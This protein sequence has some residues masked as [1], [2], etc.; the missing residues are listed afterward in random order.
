MH[1]NVQEKEPIFQYAESIAFTYFYFFMYS[2]YFFFFCIA[3][4]FFNFFYAQL[5][6]IFLVDYHEREKQITSSASYPCQNTLS[7]HHDYNDQSKR[8]VF[9]SLVYSLVAKTK[10]RRFFFLGGKVETL[11][12]FYS[13]MRATVAFRR[14]FPAPKTYKDK[15]KI[16]YKPLPRKYEN[17]I[18][19][20]SP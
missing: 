5:L 15:I 17:K 13:L 1:T 20:T 3:F 12:G 19:N 4:T 8:S 18:K 16:Q 7:I 2:F 9:F 11:R 14:L 10:A 6:L